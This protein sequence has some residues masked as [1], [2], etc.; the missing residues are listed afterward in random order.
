MKK[1]KKLHFAPPMGLAHGPEQT[2]G[3]PASKPSSGSHVSESGLMEAC[4]S[5]L[6]GETQVHMRPLGR[7]RNEAEGDHG[8][9]TRC[10]QKQVCHPRN[11]F[12][13]WL[14]PL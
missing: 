5:L 3:F 4:F 13:P 6:S 2:V 11:Y 9:M 1:K 12:S 10:D 14:K 8:L 7:D